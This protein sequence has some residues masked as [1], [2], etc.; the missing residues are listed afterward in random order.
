MKNI[1]ASGKRKTA[2]A[3]ATL[4]QGNG[5]IRI[6]KTPIELVYPKIS[7]LKLREPL[8]LAGDAAGKIDVDVT[9]IGGGITSQAEASRLA[10]AKAL[11]SF[12]KNDK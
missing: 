3:R 12:T 7:R 11:V 1:H 5:L 6:N 2:I 10:I 8:I 4:R 9:V